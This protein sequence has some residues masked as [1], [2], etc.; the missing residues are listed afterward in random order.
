[1]VS[2]SA[3]ALAV[4]CESRTNALARRMSREFFESVPGYGTL[5]ADVKDLEI[6]ATVRHGVRLF[7]RGVISPPPAPDG[8][9]LFRE[10]AAQRAEEGVPLDLLLRTY[11]LGVYGLWQVMREEAGPD[12]GSALAELVDLLFRSQTEVV[13]AVTQHYLQQRDALEAA[14]RTDRIRLVRALLHGVLDPD[15]ARRAGLVL[16]GPLLLLAFRAGRADAPDGPV[17]ERRR[18]RRIRAALQSAFGADVPAL[19]DEAPDGG[20]AWGQALVAGCEEVPEDLPRLLEEGYGAPVRVAAAVARDA[21]GIPE[22]SRTAGEIVRIARARGLPAGTVHRLDDVLLEFHLSR[23]GP[24]GDRIAA[25]LDPVADRPELLAT[26][27]THLELCLDRRSTASA[28]GV[29]PNTVDKRL[30]RLA[31]LTGLDLSSPHGTA[32]ALAAQLLREAP[33]R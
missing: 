4:R 29:H 25:L 12:E 8:Y 19:T 2:D 21:S 20:G 16:D 5:P 9:R 13:G 32:L 23:P 11:A 26:L 33:A 30:T 17:A 28:L 3:R 24:S 14:R 18:Q 22:A 10:R 7:L 1:M 15:E 6:A 27:R 31:A